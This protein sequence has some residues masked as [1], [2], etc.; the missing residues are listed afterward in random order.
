MTREEFTI[1]GAL[2]T[3]LF[4]PWIERH[5]ARLGVEMRLRDS[6]PERLAVEFEGAPALLDAMEMGCLLGPID[7]WVE[8]IVRKRVSAT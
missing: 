1:E 8:S 6:A 4:L 3:P 5:A 2:G 7:A